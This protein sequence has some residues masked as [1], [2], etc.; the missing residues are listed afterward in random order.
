MWSSETGNNSD[1]DVTQTLDAESDDGS[2]NC[3]SE[4]DIDPHDD[5]ARAGHVGSSVAT[6]MCHFA[7][8]W[9]I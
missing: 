7:R 6:S 9:A 8:V 3:E 4:S 2:N 1:N 5:T